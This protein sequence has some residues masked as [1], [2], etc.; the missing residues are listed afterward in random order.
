M[1]MADTMIVWILAYVWIFCILAGFIIAA[2]LGSRRSA[3][4]EEAAEQLEREQDGLYERYRSAYR[5]DPSNT[6]DGQVYHSWEIVDM[7]VGSMDEATAGRHG[8]APTIIQEPVP[9]YY[10]LPNYSETA[11]KHSDSSDIGSFWRASRHADK[12]H[13]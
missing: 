7:P 4:K 8:Q 9:A 10:A 11:N 3:C 2:I 5:Q 12:L 6:A 13:S 1:P